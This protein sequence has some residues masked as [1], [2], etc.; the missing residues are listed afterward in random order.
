MPKI[1][2]KDLVIGSMDVK[3]LYPS[4]RVAKTTK[5]IIESFRK[6][7]LEFTEI[8]IPFLLKF[9]SIITKGVT[10]I[11]ELDIYLQVPKNRTTLNSWLRRKSE[12]QCQGPPLED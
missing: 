2:G 6:A 8:N 4:C 5:V 7:E 3:A 12:T 1:Q 11:P 10:G 9:V